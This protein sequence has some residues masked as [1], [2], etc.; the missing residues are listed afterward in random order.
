M[1]KKYISMLDLENNNRQPAYSSGEKVPSKETNLPAKTRN[2]SI[3]VALVLLLLVGGGIGVISYLD[4]Q[5]K[6]GEE[7][8]VAEKSEYEIVYYDLKDI[9]VNLNTG[10]KMMSFMKL[11]ISLEV[12]GKDNLNALLKFTPKIKD[13]FQLYLRELRPEDTRGSVG[14]YKLKEELMIRVNKIIYPAYINDILFK[15]ILVQ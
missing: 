7:R 6:L 8:Q 11:K 15:E 13:V 3:I 12:S 4:H 9:I 14:L 10:G 1:Y 2:N 5:K